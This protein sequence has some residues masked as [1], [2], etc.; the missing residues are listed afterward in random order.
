M[1]I[2]MIILLLQCMVTRKDNPSVNSAQ[3]QN[4]K[5]KIASSVFVV[6]NQEIYKNKE[7]SYMEDSYYILLSQI[8]DSNKFV[9]IQ[10]DIAKADLILEIETETH[11]ENNRYLPLLTILTLTLFPYYETITLE[12]NFR[13]V[14]KNG[15]IVFQTNRKQK[16]GYW[17][18]ILFSVN[19]LIQASKSED[20]NRFGFEKELIEKMNRSILEEL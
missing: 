6:L 9:S 19:G 12:E 17:F 16:L 3:P 20:H 2:L 18:G 4:L 10:E 5:G 8:R 15:E 11:K 1:R 14:K 7:K 13:L